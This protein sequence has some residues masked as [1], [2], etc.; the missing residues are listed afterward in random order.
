MLA[1]IPGLVQLENLLIVYGLRM[2]AVIIILLA[3]RWVAKLAAA[4]VR[5]TLEAAPHLDVTVTAFLASL[6]YYGTLAV[7]FVLILQV[8]GVQATSLVAILGTVSLAIGLALQGTLSN[9]AAGVMLLIFRPFRIGD[10]IEVAGKSGTVVNLNV[11]MTEI[12]A[13]DNVKILVPNG[14][15][16]GAAAITNL[17]AY[18]TRRISMTMAVPIDQDPEV[19]A[20]HLRGRIAQDRLFLPT[21]APTVTVTALRETDVELTAQAWART[22]DIV[23]ARED[24]IRHLRDLRRDKAD[25]DRDREDGNLP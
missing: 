9:L 2:I 24:M 21:P 14:Q 25:K 20:A 7:T 5:R 16:W 10:M 15:V 11:F 22:Q 13:G 6:A 3:G 1:D 12:A 8:A 17:T 19:A 4:A 23:Q 18:P